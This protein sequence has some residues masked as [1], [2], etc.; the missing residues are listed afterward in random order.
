MVRRIRN[1]I[2]FLVLIVHWC[3]CYQATGSGPASTATVQKVGFWVSA[4]LVTK[5]LMALTF[6]LSF[7]LVSNLQSSVYPSSSELGA[8]P[9]AWFGVMWILNPMVA[10]LLVICVIVFLETIPSKFSS[11]VIA[12]YILLFALLMMCFEGCSQ[13]SVVASI[14]SRNYGF[15]YTVVGRLLFMVFMG[16][17]LCALQSNFGYAMSG[18]TI[19]TAVLN[20]VVMVVFPDC[21]EEVSFAL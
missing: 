15:M 11:W 1:T 7:S 20:A 12:I 14:L 19:A 9:W 4:L 6:H 18:I 17:M 8:M 3:L 13:V 2:F 5:F 10:L 16:I 21:R